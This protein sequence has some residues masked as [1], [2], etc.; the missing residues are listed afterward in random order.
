MLSEKDLADLA[1]VG[2]CSKYRE[3]LDG[4]D[5]YSINQ[6]QVRALGQEVR[7]KR[8]KY[9]H[10]PHRSNTHIVEYDSDSSDDEDKEVYATE[11]VWPAAAKPC[12]C[13]SLKPTQRN[14]QEEMKFTFYVSKCNRIFYELL[15]LGHLNINHVIPLLEELKRHAYYK[16]HN[17]S[18]HATND[19]NVFRRQVQSAINEG[20]LTFPEM[21]LDKVPFP[22][23][24]IDLNNAKVLIRP[25]QTEG[26][27]GKNVI[28][29]DER[30]L[31]IDNKIL[32][33]EVV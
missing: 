32:A 6:L 33:W 15:R 2:L 21:K 28:I 22:M 18:S 17:S 23:H 19:C 7:F 24:T 29:G 20:R 4:M 11:F 10:N 5:H 14:Q 8:E 1:L 25:D 26:A 9:T 3:K 31:I 27:K 12:S 13:A 30:P 16:F